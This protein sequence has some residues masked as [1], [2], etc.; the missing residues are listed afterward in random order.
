MKNPTQR[1]KRLIQFFVDRCDLTRIKL[2]FIFAATCDLNEAI[3]YFEKRGAHIHNTSTKLEDILVTQYRKVFEES[4]YNDLD[5]DDNLKLKKKS[6]LVE[7]YVE[8]AKL[9]SNAEL[10]VGSDVSKE[11]RA[12]GLTPDSSQMKWFYDDVKKFHLEA[13]RKLQKYFRTVL[14]STVMDN[15]SALDQKFQSHIATSRKLKNLS[16]QYSK[17]VDS[18]QFVDG[19][20]KIRTEIEKYVTDEDVMELDKEEGLESFW[21]NVKKITDGIEKWPRC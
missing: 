20:D 21:S 5:E 16:S 14:T 11:I 17:I 13:C 9:L 4:V 15:M 6:E 12:L 8:K 2:K 10:F 7:I 3:D 18:I 19:R 1:Q